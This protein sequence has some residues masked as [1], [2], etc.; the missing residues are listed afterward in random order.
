MTLSSPILCARVVKYCYSADTDNSKYTHTPQASYACAI[1]Q[2]SMEYK[3]KY[4]HQITVND[5]F[6]DHLVDA[7]YTSIT[8]YYVINASRAG[9]ENIV[10]ATLLIL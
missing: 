1:R 6:P 4:L 5:L 10:I 8:D 3:W 2:G 7:I 9:R